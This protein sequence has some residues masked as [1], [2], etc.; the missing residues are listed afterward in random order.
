M[1]YT[2]QYFLVRIFLGFGFIQRPYVHDSILASEDFFRF[3][4]HSNTIQYLLVRIFLG[5]GVMD[6]LC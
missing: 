2:I 1:T 5:F 4:V 3:W 6:E